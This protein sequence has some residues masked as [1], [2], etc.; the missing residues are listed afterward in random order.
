MQIIRRLECRYFEHIFKKWNINIIFVLDNNN[1]KSFLKFLL[2][3]LSTFTWKALN[4]CVLIPNF[5]A[6]HIKYHASCLIWR[7]Q[8]V[9]RLTAHQL[10]IQNVAAWP[11]RKEITSTA[12]Q[13]TILTGVCVSECV[14]VCD[15]EGWRPR[16]TR[17]IMFSSTVNYQNPKAEGE[18]GTEMKT[19]DVYFMRIN[20]E[21]RLHIPVWNINNLHQV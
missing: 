12:T 10:S 9:Y 14:C 19:A 4:K 7:G 13:L 1:F 11:S 16:F 8:R 6:G 15:T 5:C 3:S 20:V 21:G 2:R 18:G 17:R